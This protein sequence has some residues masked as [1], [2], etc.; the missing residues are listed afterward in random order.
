MLAGLG[1]AAAAAYAV[2]LDGGLFGTTGSYPSRS[3]G[4]SELTLDRFAPHVGSTF[5]VLTGD[6]LLPLRLTLVEASA[7]PPHAADDRTRLIGEAF[8]LVFQGERVQR[9]LGQ[10]PT[11]VIHPALGRFRL[12]V[13]PFGRAAGVQQYQAVVDRRVPRR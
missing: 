8:S 13:A 5:A 6:S 11:T 2:R 10:R 1:V 3:A 7:R 4:P 12:S 9:P